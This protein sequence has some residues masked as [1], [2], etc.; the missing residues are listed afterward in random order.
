MDDIYKIRLEM[1]KL[2][3]S[4]E[5]RFSTL[6]WE[7]GY[8]YSIWFKRIDWHG[9]NAYSITGHHICF[10][11]HIKDGGNYEKVLETVK[12]CADKAKKAWKDFPESIPHQFTNGIRED[13]MLIK[14]EDGK[15]FSQ[16]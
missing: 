3:W 15:E 11:E 14:F 9:K 13:I 4:S 8:G 5:D 6:G 12:K 16:L 7:N 10:H 2:G 1:K